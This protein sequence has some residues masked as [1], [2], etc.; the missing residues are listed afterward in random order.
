MNQMTR[1]D[2]ELSVRAKRWMSP[3]FRDCIF[4]VCVLARLRC[5]KTENHWCDK[6]ICK[7]SRHLLW[8]QS[9]LIYRCVNL[10]QITIYIK[11][12]RLRQFTKK[13]NSQ[14][15]PTSSS[16]KWR[17]IKKQSGQ[18]FYTEYLS[19]WNLFQPINKLKR[20][21]FETEKRQ[22]GSRSTA[23]YFRIIFYG[24]VCEA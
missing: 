9:A 4:M 3:I 17:L 11:E 19:I 5:I 8:K 12:S 24:G 2:K 14:R 13:K 21:F 22:Q 1:E 10:W 15:Q 7:H 6:A 16:E 20:I 23:L 18:P